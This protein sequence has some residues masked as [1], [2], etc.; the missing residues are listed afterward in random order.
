MPK[1]RISSVEG[2]K[3]R[4]RFQFGHHELLVDEPVESGGTDAG[5]DPYALMLGALGACTSMTIRLYAERKGWNVSR[6]EIELEHDRVHAKD[7]EDCESDAAIVERVTRRIRIFGELSAEQRKR[8]AE[9]A[10]RCPVH[11]TLV[12]GMVVRDEVTEG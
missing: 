10:R 8:L 2:F 9:I 6:V 7:C 11:K 4:Q 12:A 5:P 3:F 1:V